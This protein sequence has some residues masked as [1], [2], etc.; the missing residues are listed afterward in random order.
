MQISNRTSLPRAAAAIVAVLGSGALLFQ[1][2]IARAADIPARAEAPAPAPIAAPPVFTWTGFYFGA[3]AGWA[4][5]KRKVGFNVTPGANNPNIA[6]LTQN[7]GI[8]GLQTGYNWQMGPLV[9]GIETDIQ[10]TS[11]RKKFGPVALAGG[12]TATGSNAVS[13]YGTLR[14][15]IGYAFN[16]TMLYATGGLAY[17]NVRNRL[18]SIDGAGN[19]FTM[20]GSKTR[21]G[22][23]VGAGV[24]HAF[25][26][27]WS[28]KLEYGY[29]DLG[30]NSQSAAV[31]NGGVATGAIATSATR[32][33]FHTLRA[34][35]NY[36]F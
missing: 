3:N 35:V 13:W 21:V 17:G 25:N 29:V 16:Q 9:L 4:I 28:A 7:G 5:A 23:T 20:P 24:E 2:G 26:Q 30:R 11:L 27:N 12:G 36:R 6:N 22:W 19:T 14:P 1:A 33:A 32:S 18:T 31:F 15:R 10:A 8:I 34:G